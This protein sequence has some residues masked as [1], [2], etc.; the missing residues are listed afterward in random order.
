VTASLLVEAIF[1]GKAVSGGVQVVDKKRKHKKTEDEMKEGE[2]GHHEEWALVG[3][4]VMNKFEVCHLAAAD[5][6]TSLETSV[7]DAGW[8]ERW[9]IIQDLWAHRCP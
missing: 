4:E 8:T 6:F 7:Q 5:P 2:K 3:V 9:V 1:K